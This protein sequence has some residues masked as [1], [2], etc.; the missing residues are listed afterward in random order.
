[1]LSVA[2]AQAVLLGCVEALDAETAP[3][4][5][6]YGRVLAAPIIAAR[7]QPPF[8]AS[9]M[10]GYASA[11]TGAPTDLRIVGEAAAGRA[12]PRVLRA[13]EA[14]RIST[15]APIPEGAEGVLIQEDAR[16]DGETLRG[17]QIKPGAHIRPRGGDFLAGQLLLERGRL[18]DP[19][20]VALAASA[21]LASLPVVRRPRIAVMAS[22]DEIVTPGATARA[23][24]VFESGAF[25]VC[26]LLEAWGGEA[27]R[28]PIL[29]DEETAIARLASEALKECDLLV[30]IG[31]ASV[32]PHDHARQA[33]A[34]LGL[35]VRFDKVAVRPGKPTWFATGARGK[36]LGLPGNPAS[37]IVC[38]ILFLRPIVA[39]MLGD[40]AAQPARPRL[41]PL[42]APLPANGP[43]ESYL[44]ARLEPDG[45]LT[46][47]DN[48]DS[49]L[50]SVF[51]HANAL[52]LRAPNAPAAATSALAPYLLI[53]G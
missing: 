36:V 38:A 17:A 1:M 7:D 39:A 44:R 18:L 53:E 15:G 48:Q 21:G 35:D 31:G 23:E 33:L 27:V 4:D 29:P 26:G 22:G 43:R 49:S 11:C 3:L 10:D 42:A 52:A 50:L 34:G 16:R 51:A 45:R 40:G 30:L 5:H 41:A 37:A 14:V 19:I 12:F 13:R 9:A 28:G 25:A 24:Q 32:G 47:F 6:A 8:A 46:V 2:E 20:A